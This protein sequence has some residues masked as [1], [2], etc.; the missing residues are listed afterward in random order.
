MPS[1][2]EIQHFVINRLE[3]Q[4]VYDHLVQTGQV[5]DDELYFIQGEG[6]VATEDENGLMSSSDKSKLNG[7][8]EGATNTIVDD[9]LTSTSQTHAL[10]ANQGKILNDKIKSISDNIEAVLTSL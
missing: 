10:S 7:I 5:N 8:E 3:S 1:D 4:E 9:V 6:E 2:K